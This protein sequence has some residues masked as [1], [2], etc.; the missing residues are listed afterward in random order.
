MPYD[1][2][3]DD[4]DD[5]IRAG[6]SL[7]STW[8]ELLSISCTTNSQQMEQVEFELNPSSS[9]SSIGRVVGGR[10]SCCSSGPVDDRHRQ[11]SD[12]WTALSGQWSEWMG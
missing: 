3:D 8:F 6:Y 1:D 11:P 4:D 5:I 2:D 9:S 10:S 7:N 12:V